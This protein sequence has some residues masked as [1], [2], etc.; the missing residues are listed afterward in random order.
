MKRIIAALL[1]GLTATTANAAIICKETGRELNGK[2]ASFEFHGE[3][4]IYNTLDYNGSGVT[5]FPLICEQD[6]KGYHSCYMERSNY[7]LTVVLINDLVVTSMVSA[8]EPIS[9]VYDELE[10]TSSL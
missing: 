9:V 1:I 5:Q 7:V 2:T 10:C 3:Y 6:L 4:G 8:F